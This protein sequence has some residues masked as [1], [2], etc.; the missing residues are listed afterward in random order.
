VA[1]EAAAYNAALLGQKATTVKTQTARMST[2]DKHNQTRYPIK[3]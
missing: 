3:Y 1:Q 2:A